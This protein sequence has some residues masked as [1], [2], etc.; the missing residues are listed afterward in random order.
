MSNKRIQKK[1]AKADMR[2]DKSKVIAS[3]IVLLDSERPRYEQIKTAKRLWKMSLEELL[4]LSERAIRVWVS[5]HSPFRS[6]IPRKSWEGEL[7]QWK[8]VVSFS[9]EVK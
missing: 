7:V 3:I 6:M 5:Y 9:S 2:R 1:R 8:P 4:D